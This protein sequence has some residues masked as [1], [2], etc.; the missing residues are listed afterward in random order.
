MIGRL[1]GKVSCITDHV[2]VDIGGVGYLI[3][4][5][6]MVLSSLIEN[7]YYQFFIETHVR[8]DHIHLYGFLSQH[9]KY[10]FTMLLLVNGI[11]PRMALAILS[12]LTPDQIATAISSKDKNAFRVV[13][14]VGAKIAERIIIELRDKL[15]HI[16][17][18][19]A[20]INL[21]RDNDI[22][23]DAM[24]AL[25]NLGVNKA[26]AQNII[27]KILATQPDISIDELI[28]SFFKLR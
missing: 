19:T 18:F 25:V 7:E 22:A 1:Y 14:G 13:S 6:T 23:T 16:T 21:S 10:V 17:I 15:S 20:N 12:H 27:S 5:S 11:G 24:L 2:I 3:Y 9:E 26:E 28:R 8:E 4:C